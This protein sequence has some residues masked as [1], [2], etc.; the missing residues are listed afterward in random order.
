MAD[1]ILLTSCD[2]IRTQFNISDNVTDKFIMPSIRETQE[3][4]LQQTIGTSL[5]KKLQELV[6]TGDISLSGNT[7]YKL[8]LDN[9]QWMLAYHTIAKIC[10]MASTKVSNTGVYQTSDEHENPYYLTDMFRIKDEYIIK[11]DFYTNRLQD[12]IIANRDKYPELC[13]NNEFD[14]IKANLYSAASTGMWLGGARGKGYKNKCR[15]IGYDRP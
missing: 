8:L 14:K 10:F 13:D 4:E 5:Y 6:R 2:F 12:F 1:T 9:A 7:D 15:H 3:I 11:A